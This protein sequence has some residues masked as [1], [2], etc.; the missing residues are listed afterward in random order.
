[1]IIL[2]TYIMYLKETVVHAA[3]KLGY[4]L[5]DKQRMTKCYHPPLVQVT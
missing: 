5:G 3:P 1:M 4:T 2:F